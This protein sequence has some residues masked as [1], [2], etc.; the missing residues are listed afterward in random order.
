MV[1]V[2]IDMFGELR[3]E[4]DDDQLSGLLNRRGF[5]AK[6]GAELRRCVDA[7]QLAALLIA[8]LDHFKAVNDTHGHAVGDAIIAAFG[9]HVHAVG[10][11]RMVAGRIG[12]EEFAMLVPGLAIDGAR[13]FAEAVRKGLHAACADRIPTSLCPTVSIGLAVGT[14]GE[15]LSRLMRDADHALYE[16]KRM[17]RNRVR[18]FRPA[19]VRLGA[20]A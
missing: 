10:P 15:G 2:A 12:G 13:Q 5:E 1:A 17:G 18:A 14:P 3:R 20:T 8:D 11:S 19:P 7:G 9:A 6:A 4:A 16:A